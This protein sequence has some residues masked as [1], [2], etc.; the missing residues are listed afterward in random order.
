[1]FAGQSAWKCVQKQVTSPFLLLLF[2]TYAIVRRRACDKSTSRRRRTKPWKVAKP[3]RTWGVKFRYTITRYNLQSGIMQQ[4]APE[5]RCDVE[6]NSCCAL[7]VTSSQ[8]LIIPTDHD[9][10]YIKISAPAINKV[11]DNQFCPSYRALYILALSYQ[12][13]QTFAAA[14]MQGIQPA[15]VWPPP[16]IDGSKSH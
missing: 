13:S 3:F 10:E 15:V 2:G 16:I 4:C 6:A 9:T 5:N 1:M 12:T 8:G 11:F 14:E 7:H